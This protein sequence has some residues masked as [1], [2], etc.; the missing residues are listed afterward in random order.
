MARLY[1]WYIGQLVTAGAMRNGDSSLQQG[2]WD[3]AADMGFVGVISGGDVEEHAG[4][5]NL[6]VDV[7]ASLSR[8]PLGERIR[9]PGLSTVDVQYDY[10]TQPTAITTPTYSRIVDV[11]IVFDRVLSDPRIDATNTTIYFQQDES[12]GFE[13]HQGAE[14][15]SPSA[16]AGPA[17]GVLLAR[18]TRTFGQTTIV[19]ADIDTT[20]KEFV[21]AIDSGAVSIRTGTFI[22][23]LQ[24]VLDEYVG[25]V[26]GSGAH[27]ATAITY[28]GGPAWA[29]TVTNPATT[30]ELQFDSMITKL[31]STTSGLSGLHH[32]GAASSASWA[33]GTSFTAG[34]AFALTNG[35]ISAVAATTTSASGLRKV[36]CEARTTWLGGRTN[37]GGVTAWAAVDKIITDLAA[38]GNGDDG[39]ERVGGAARTGTTYSLTAGSAA[40]QAV[41]LLGF[42]D[43]NAADIEALVYQHP[44]PGTS[45]SPTYTNSTGTFSQI[46]AVFFGSPVAE[47]AAVGDVLSIN[48]VCTANAATVYGIIALFVQ[49]PSDAF[50]VEITGARVRVAVGDDNAVNLSASHIVTESGDV[51]VFARGKCFDNS[52]TLTVVEAFRLDVTRLRPPA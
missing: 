11:Y 49:L 45:T 31:A 52:G 7:A 26:D 2:D 28:A 38:T 3:V 24:A 34:T 48:F 32:I 25:H 50:P 8:S 27:P 14:A 12:F 4:T 19:N 16:P 51:T 44:T 21:V 40:S 47:Q 42:A 10:L 37:P 5:A 9:A 33:D 17:D 36:G 46:T 15:L 23:A 20:V 43:T 29:N 35:I 6:T 41:E 13:V 18:I 22:E 30:A 39:M 1:T